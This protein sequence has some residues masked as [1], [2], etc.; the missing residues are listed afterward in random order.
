MQL[1]WRVLLSPCF[2]FCK[3]ERIFLYY[4]DNLQ[5]LNKHLSVECL[6]WYLELTKLTVN[7][8]CYFC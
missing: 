5:V 1:Q 8:S 4:Q 3:P 7:D 2:L 6:A